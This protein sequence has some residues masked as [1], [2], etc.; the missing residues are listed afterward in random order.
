MTARRAFTDMAAIEADLVAALRVIRAAVNPQ[1]GTPEDDAITHL[2]SF[3]AVA[4]RVMRK[5]NPS[6]IRSCA[7]T[8]EI[9]ARIEGRAV[10]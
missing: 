6:K 2:E 4:I 9:K 10:E 3:A 1:D 8:E 5:T 7:M